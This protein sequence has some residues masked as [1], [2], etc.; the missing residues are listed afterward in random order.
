MNALQKTMVMGATFLTSLLPSKKAEGQIAAWAGAP[1]YYVYMPVVS[2]A[3]GMV[4]PN[5]ARA[6]D[7]RRAAD[8][9]YKHAWKAQ[10]EHKKELLESGRVDSKDRF[11][12]GTEMSFVNVHW[13][14]DNKYYIMSYT[15]DYLYY[16]VASEKA[17]ADYWELYRDA[18]GDGK[19]SKGDQ[20]L[21][22][23]LLLQATY[24]NGYD[25]K[26]VMFEHNVEDGDKMTATSIVYGGNGVP[27]PYNPK[28][29]FNTS[30]VAHITLQD[31]ASDI[32]HRMVSLAASDNEF[33]RNGPGHVIQMWEDQW[34][35]NA[36][37][38][39][40]NNPVEVENFLSAFKR[41]NVPQGYK[42]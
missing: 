9:E 34:Y 13:S 35:R 3:Y 42:P 30:Y 1:R 33:T 32:L 40:L 20:L 18:D 25:K 10:K 19:V 38:G 8:K 2:N 39:D 15:S 14:N 21:T 17:A 12:Q 36:T 41:G 37:F 28:N 6:M 26:V 31:N 24:P 23:R 7:Y 5:T 27:V 29:V 11:L 4:S 16:H 22:E